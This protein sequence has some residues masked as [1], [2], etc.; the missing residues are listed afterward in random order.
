MKHDRQLQRGC[1]ADEPARDGEGTTIALR[2]TQGEPR[3]LQQ[4][5]API[6]G[7]GWTF[8]FA[9]AINAGVSVQMDG[10]GTDMSGAE[11]LRHAAHGVSGSGGSLPF[12]DVIQQ[13]FGPAHDVSGVRAH[14]GGTA[15]HAAS[16][17]GASAYA[18]GNQVAFAGVPDLHT[19]AHEAAH[20][21]QQRAGVRLS[22]NVGRAGDVYERHADAVADLVVSGQSA[23]GLLGEH[24]DLGAPGGTAVQRNP[25]TAAA[26]PAQG[27]G[28]GAPTARAPDAIGRDL[29]RQCDRIHGYAMADRAAHQRLA[30]LRYGS[31]LENRAVG[32]VSETAAAVGDAVGDTW[33]GRAIDQMRPEDEG[34]ETTD[35]HGNTTRGPVVRDVTPHRNID[36]SVEL[37]PLSI[38]NEIFTECNVVF[39][40][41]GRFEG[42]PTE[43]HLHACRTAFNLLKDK[44]EHCSQRVTEYRDRT[45]HGGDLA[46]DGLRGVVAVCAIVA[47]ICSGG[48]MG[49]ALGTAAAGT[50]G[51]LAITAAASA[52][53]G[54]VFA[55]TTG[56]AG[57][58]SEI[59]HG[60]RDHFDAG[61]IFADTVTAAVTTFIGTFTGGLGSRL[62]SRMLANHLAGAAATPALRAAFAQTRGVQFIADFLSGAGLTPLNVALNHAIA[63]IR[64]THDPRHPMTLE[65]LAHEV[66]DEMIRGGVMNV[67]MQSAQRNGHFMGI[68]APASVR[69]QGAAADVRAA[70]AAR[71]STTNEPA[72]VPN[73]QHT[74]PHTE[75]PPLR[76][77]GS[78][79]ADPPPPPTGPSR[80]ARPLEELRPPGERTADPPSPPTGEPRVARPHV[81]D[82]R[83]TDPDGNSPTLPGQRPTGDIGDAPGP[84]ATPREQTLTPHAPGTPATGTEHTDPSMRPTDPDD[85]ATLRPARRNPEPEGRLSEGSDLQDG[86]GPRAE[87]RA[88]PPTVDQITL[89]TARRV[90]AGMRRLTFATTR[91]G[92][93]GRPIRAP[94]PYHYPVDG[95][96]DRAHM[97]A[98]YLRQ[99]GIASQRLFAVSLAPE[100][101]LRVATPNTD[102]GA[103]NWQYHVAP[104]VDVTM[105][106]GQIVSMVFDPSI[107]PSRPIPWTEWM[108]AMTSHSG[109]NFEHM[110]MAQIQGLAAANGGRVPQHTAVAVVGDSNAYSP[111][112]NTADGQPVDFHSQDQTHAVNQHEA[113]RARMT[114]Y[115][116]IES[117]ADAFRGQRTNPNPD[118]L[119][120]VLSNSTADVR[121]QFRNQYPNLVN[122]VRT[123]SNP[124]AWSRVEA[125]LAAP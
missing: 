56:V 59:A 27:A 87:R 9:D 105:P 2:R 43:T 54:A 92:P 66:Y 123:G 52:G 22:D 57:Q 76:P 29:R 122:D 51:G 41:I 49:A 112:V 42:T 82:N 109:G 97:M 117:I 108:G 37:P 20:V 99:E 77:P 88:L 111:P 71:T 45:E 74:A 72:A 80:V 69:A 84:A 100:G 21:V 18:I 79:T 44:Y 24:T 46:A 7:P 47:T 15:A 121:Q 40:A 116:G 30:T 14:I 119:V 106:D 5:S 11:V 89:D 78:R 6:G 62:L 124:S 67:L 13:S 17:I 81:D 58:A 28:P 115:A 38:W 73:A 102:S 23:A 114:G 16:A 103:Q 85:R 48:I 110:T 68:E 86:P 53:T 64:G 34:A 63:R 31:G 25:P 12:G 26:A 55:A 36:A 95:C 4:P 70:A 39:A 91:T 60:E 104:M 33:L 120:N 107:D 98:Q 101:G 65:S 8:S 19:A 94:V 61:R 96:Y 75:L 1:E 118:A 50:T 93:D 10:G 83:P 35:S 125:A 3:A 90:L 113:V 32:R